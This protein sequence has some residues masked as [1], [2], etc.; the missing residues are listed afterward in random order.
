LDNNGS[1]YNDWKFRI[2]ALLKIKGLMGIVRGTEKC[3]PKKATDPKDQVAVTT[4]FDKWHAWNDQAFVEIVMTLKKELSRKIRQFELASEVWNYLE[5]FYQ[6]KSQHKVAQLFVDIFKGH[7]I[8]TISMEEQLT[9]MNEKVHKLKNLGY[10]FKDATIAMLIMVSLPDSYAS[11]RQYLYIKDEDTLTMDFVI[12]QILLEENARGDAS[13]V[14]LMGEGKGKKPVKQSQDPSVDSNAKKK[15]MKCHYCKRKGHFKSECKKLKADQAAGTVSENRKVKE[16]KTQT[17]K[18]AA[19]SEE[20]DV[21]CLFMAQGSTLGLAGRW[22]I[23]SE[24]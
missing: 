22:I 20:E 9:D 10:E 14:T 11:L 2:S 19:T 6:G 18:I 17:A 24:V 7:F 8:D 13:H 4:A 3:S 21:V 23:D 1:N 16:S 15:N 5:S 12:K